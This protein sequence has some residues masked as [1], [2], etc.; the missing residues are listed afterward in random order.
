MVNREVQ[1]NWVRWCA[2]IVLAPWDAYAQWLLELRSLRPTWTIQWGLISEKEAKSKTQLSVLHHLWDSCIFCHSVIH[3]TGQWWSSGWKN[4]SFGEPSPLLHPL[5]T[6]TTWSTH[7]SIGP[8]YISGTVKAWERAWSLWPSSQLWEHW[9]GG[10][11]CLHY[12]NVG[13]DP[14]QVWS[15]KICQHL[16]P[17]C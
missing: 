17:L 1:I 4:L 12:Y 11:W 6:S 5:L 10:R 16:C 7:S 14:L 8:T 2:L 9:T 13:Q 15:K 3:E